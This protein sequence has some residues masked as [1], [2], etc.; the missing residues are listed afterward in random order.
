MLSWVVLGQH[1][2]EGRG[3]APDRVRSG[4]KGEVRVKT[5][6]EEHQFAEHLAVRARLAS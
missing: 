3:S 6:T 4:D 5:S 2:G 1:E